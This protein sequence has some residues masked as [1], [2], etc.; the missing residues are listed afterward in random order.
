MLTPVPGQDLPTK[1]SKKLINFDCSCGNRKL[2]RWAYYATGQSKTCGKCGLKPSSYWGNMKFGKLKMK[3]PIDIHEFSSKKVK[4]LCDCGNETLVTVS[5]VTGGNTNS[6]GKCNVLKK[7]YWENIKY[8]NLKLKNPTDLHERSHKKVAWLCDCGNEADII[9]HNV[10]RNLQKTCGKCNVLKK[11]HWENTKYGKLK[12]KIPMDL[13]KG[14]DKKVEWLCDCGKETSTYVNEVT[15]DGAKSCGKCSIL[16]AEYFKNA[17]FGRLKLKIPVDLYPVSHKKVEWICD[18]GNEALIQAGNVIR[19]LQISCGYCHIQVR[20]KYEFHKEKILKLKTPIFPDQISEFITILEP[21][22]HT[23]HP[24]RA[25]CLAC[26]S[27]HKPIW[28]NMRFGRALTCGCTSK[29]S[30]AQIDISYFIKSLNLDALLEYELNNLK[31]DIF[32]PSENTLIEYNGLKWH[33]TENSKIRDL[34]K[35]ENA[36]NGG[37]NFIMIFEDEWTQNRSKVE[38]FLKNKFKLKN[39]TPLRPSKCS[40]LMVDFLAADT[41]Y[42]EFHYIGKVKAKINYGVFHEDELIACVSF[43]NPT[44]K[45]KYQWELVRMASNPEF[46]IHG[47][48]SKIMKR[49]IVD[50]KPKSIVSFSD[51]RLFSG[52]VYEKIGFKFD[53]KIRPDYYWV[54]NQKRHHKSGLRKRSYEKNLNLTEYQIRESQGYKRIWDLGKKRWVVDNLSYS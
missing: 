51:N 24:I 41:F 19:G 49:F 54:K 1:G 43:K 53:G 32:V 30:K 10:T 9:V 2:I 29:I 25:L 50:F 7:E 13:H 8:G 35:Y 26:K 45:S 12:L 15:S 36:I 20:Q 44:R 16:S 38:N 47:I 4:W 14:S 46:R 48:W 31:Y 6:C 21:I 42:E 3:F 33:S 40:L 17:K 34:K 23:E 5:L 27:E 37:Y 28:G 11:D 39:S 22:I 18:C 52:G